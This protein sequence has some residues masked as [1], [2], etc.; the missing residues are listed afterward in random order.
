MGLVSALFVIVLAVTGI[1]LNHG[2]RFGLDSASPPQTFLSFFYAIDTP[3]IQSTAVGG[4]TVSQVNGR[5]L[6]IGAKPIAECEGELV[7][8]IEVENWLLVACAGQLVLLT[9]AGEFVDQL[10]A[11]SGLPLPIKQLGF[12]HQQA[13]WQTDTRSYALNP[14]TMQWQAVEIAPEALAGLLAPPAEL[15]TAL[16][17]NYRSDIRW[18][19]WLL[20][21]HSGRL[22][23]SLGPLLIDLMAG[24]FIIIA[25]TG[26]LM[27][28][29]GRRRSR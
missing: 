11:L 28:T 25:T 16:L 3:A 7:G 5:Q 27:W 19:R 10:N 14:E 20:D 2:H 23:G 12:C 15:Q 18:E 8:A 17:A 26:V 22:F 13:C 24:L 9:R 6:F 21:L 29:L 1:L 4:Q